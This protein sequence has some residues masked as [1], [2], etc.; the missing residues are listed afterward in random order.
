MQ[1]NDP[2]LTRKCIHFPIDIRV[3]HI[4]THFHTKVQKTPTKQHGLYV[5][6]VMSNSTMHEGKIKLA[7]FILVHRIA[8]ISKNEFVII[9]NE[10]KCSEGGLSNTR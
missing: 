10:E 7:K 5:F 1:I 4:P 2:Y 3:T 9:Q 6:E 8:K